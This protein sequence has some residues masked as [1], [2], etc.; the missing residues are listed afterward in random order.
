MRSR[1][2]DVF[3]LA[4]ASR[5]CVAFLLHR[6][7]GRQIRHVGRRARFRRVHLTNESL[8]QYRQC[9]IRW[10]IVMFLG[11]SLWEA[12]MHDGLGIVGGADS[13]SGQ[14]FHINNLRTSLLLGP[15][16]GTKAIINDHIRHPMDFFL[17]TKR[18]LM[19]MK[20]TQGM[21]KFMKNGGLSIRS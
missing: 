11:P 6:R 13:G 15:S 7:G 9:Q 14:R 21:T 8:I 18:A 20:Q 5:A 19:F 2:A 12:V 4:I 1:L 17:S 10:L 16:L 3:L